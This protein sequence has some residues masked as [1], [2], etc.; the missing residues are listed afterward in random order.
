MK[1]NRPNS[2]LPRIV[3]PFLVPWESISP[4]HINHSVKGIAALMLGEFQHCVLGC[5]HGMMANLCGVEASKGH[6]EV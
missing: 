2:L 3:V 1:G 6:Y 5:S 4:L